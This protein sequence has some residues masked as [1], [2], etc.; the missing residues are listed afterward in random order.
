MALAEQLQ[1]L[2]PYGN[3]N[4]T[5][6]FLST[7][8]TVEGDRRFGREGEHRLLVVGS[9]SGERRTVHLFNATDVELPN[10]PLD[11]V[12]TIGINNYRGER[13]LQLRYIASRASQVESSDV[14]VAAPKPLVQLHDLRNAPLAL[15]QLP[16]PA[17]AT[18]YAEGSKLEAMGI[19][20]AP[21]HATST[22]RGR[23]LVIFSAPPSAHLLRLLHD[24]HQPSAIYLVGQ[25]SNDDSVEGVLRTVAGMCKY[26]LQRGQPLQLDR[27]AA[28]LGLTTQVIRHCLLWLQAKS[29]LSLQGWEQDDTVQI[30]SAPQNGSQNSSQ[31]G[32]NK[33]DTETTAL[34]LAQLSELLAEVRAYRRYFLRAKIN[35]LGLPAA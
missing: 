29:Q 28:R 10:G 4:S 12:Y 25:L 16:S 20:Y 1:R 24:Q 34:L 7:Q 21:R 17:N 19:T 3:G 9:R 2:A 15:D 5:P 11:L 31:N 33:G 18:W 26:A 35:A 30:S 13:T 6:H 23:P 27:M 14:A 32:Q 8:L 22:Q